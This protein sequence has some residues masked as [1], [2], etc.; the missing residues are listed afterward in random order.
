ML[1]VL[2]VLGLSVN[3][4]SGDDFQSRG[5]WRGRV[6]DEAL[7]ARW[8][9]FGFCNIVHGHVKPPEVEYEEEEEEH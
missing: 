1:L 7:G 2:G 3:E 6:E 8:S 5:R 9:M 4:S